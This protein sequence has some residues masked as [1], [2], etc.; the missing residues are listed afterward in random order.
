[1]G[2]SKHQTLQ[3]RVRSP[4]WSRDAWSFFAEKD[5]R[6]AW[7][8][9]T[10]PIRKRSLN[11]SGSGFLTTAMMHGVRGSMGLGMSK[12]SALKGGGRVRVAIWGKKILRMIW[13]LSTSSTSDPKRKGASPT[14][15]GHDQRWW[16]EEGRRGLL[17]AYT[18]A[19]WKERGYLTITGNIGQIYKKVASDGFEVSQQGLFSHVLW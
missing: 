5:R 9:L 16:M 3:N 4:P 7:L 13:E 17:V 8:S 14:C 6:T 12:K 2:S 1:M 11:W 18:N 15:L 19:F 10:T